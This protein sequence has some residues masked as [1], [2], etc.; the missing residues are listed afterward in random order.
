MIYI[1]YF[2]AA[3]L[4]FFSWKSLR[5]GREYLNFFRRELAREKSSYRPFVS[6]IAPC[7]GLDR[8]LEKNLEK[9]FEQ[10]YP[11]YEVIF[12][13]DDR[14]DEAVKVIEKLLDKDDGRAR[15]KLVVAGPARDEG[16]KV[17]NLR[18]AVL[19]A[20]AES[21]V[22]VFVDSD[23]RP[24]REWLGHLVAPLADE[25]VGCATGYRW[26]IS[27]RR[28]FAS[29]MLSVWNASVASALGANTRSNFCWGG[30]MAL[31]RATFEKIGMRERLKG[32][33]SDDFAVTRAMKEN[34]LAVYFVP[35]ALT[36]SFE[37]CTPAGLLEFTTRQMKI[38]RVY[39][40]HL[41]RASFIGSFLFNL[42]ML[43]AAAV[44]FLSPKFGFSFWFAALTV[45]AVSVFSIG[46][47]HLRLKAVKLVLTAYRTELDR[48]TL[49]QL[50]LWALSPALFFYNSACALFSRE[51][52]W[53]G[54]RYKL[55]SPFRTS[56]LGP[57][58]C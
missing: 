2:L 6:V 52:L 33:V 18:E 22:F 36:A 55:E 3:V 5:G 4:I 7:R 24:A 41:W 31:R 54:I 1:F 16:Q 23:A 8:E 30:S 32:T 51:I 37:D 42:V 20:A 25:Q 10:D 46:K 12:V 56:K 39:A 44:V 34:S 58:D 49:P 57:G 19:H 38:T 35:Q 40:P 14:R 26:F 21:E 13:V 43:W 17:H 11:A 28:N 15:S 53:R 29:E 27:R 47:A 50:T 45:T 48:Q 9:L